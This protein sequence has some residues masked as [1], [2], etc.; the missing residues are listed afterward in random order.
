M[1]QVL[2]L[3]ACL[4]P[5]T[6]CLLAFLSCVVDLVSCQHNRQICVGTPNNIHKQE[7]ASMLRW[8]LEARIGAELKCSG[9]WRRPLLGM[10][11]N[12]RQDKIGA[13]CPNVLVDWRREP[14]SGPADS[15]LLGA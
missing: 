12:S 5:E 8:H 4:V 15:P 2:H 10:E 11:R 6:V 14:R 3:V 9:L 1:P 7:H 13:L